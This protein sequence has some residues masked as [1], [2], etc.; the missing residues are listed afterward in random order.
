MRL[1][2]A[3]TKAGIVKTVQV[4]FGGYDRRAEAADGTFR[5]T[6]NLTSDRWPLVTA[7]KRRYFKAVTGPVATVDGICGGDALITVINGDHVYYEDWELCRTPTAGVK[8]LVRFG[9]NVIIFPDKIMLDLSRELAGRVT[10][11]SGIVDPQEGEAWAVGAEGAQN[12]TIYVYEGGVWVEAG[13]VWKALETR[14]TLDGAYFSNGYFEEEQAEMNTIYQEPPE[15]DDYRVYFKTGDALTISGC[16][17]QPWNNQTFIVREVRADALVFYENTFRKPAELI[18]KPTQTLP[19][20]EDETFLNGYTV[21]N[22][23]GEADSFTLGD[24]VLETDLLVYERENHG[25]MHWRDGVEYDFYPLVAWPP[26]GVNPQAEPAVLDFERGVNDQAARFLETGQV[27]IERKIPEMDFIFT[28]DNRLWGCKG[29]T[30]YASKLGDPSNFWFNDIT[31]QD[32][33]SV[34]VAS[35]GDFT[36]A[37][38]HDGYPTFFKEHKRYKVYCGERPQYWSLAEL[39]CQGVKEGAGKSLAI[40]GN[41]LFYLS[42]G[43]IMADSGAEPVLISQELGLRVYAGGVGGADAHKYWIWLSDGTLSEL[44]CYDTRFRIWILDNG[45]AVYNFAAVRGVLYGHNNS[46]VWAMVEPEDTDGWT[47]ENAF[48]A[49]FETNDYVAEEPNRKRV[50]RVQL[51]LRI[52]AET[53]VEVKIQYDNGTVW[54]TVRTITGDG[55]KGSRYLPVKLRRCDHFRLRIE[56][57]GEWELSSM[58]LEVKKESAIH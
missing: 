14:V 31:A 55:G 17:T 15:I 9:K 22:E 42:R 5:E 4:R 46:R 51:R 50:H 8:Q 23:P 19:K 3:V 57:R 43:G 53:E 24:D 47:R 30:I 32:S 44:Y 13:P 35:F 21:G 48:L 16:V 58:A 40:V 45:T 36:G 41:T 52:E 54:H 26:A 7:R 28:N 12:P 6:G 1:P 2:D 33:W 38:S 20:M 25:V 37:I 34:D 18:L 27:K 49:Y 29:S 39:D 56:G 11:G 10:D